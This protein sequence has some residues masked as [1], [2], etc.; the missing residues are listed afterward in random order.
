MALF[1]GA[2]TPL[3]VVAADLLDDAVRCADGENH[4]CGVHCL[5]DGLCRCG[6]R[7]GV[8][9]LITVPCGS[10]DCGGL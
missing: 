3:F 10:H 2:H 4:E 7:F 9:H 8:R 6:L 5:G 1:V